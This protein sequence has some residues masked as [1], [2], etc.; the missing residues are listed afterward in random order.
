MLPRLTLVLLLLAPKCWDYGYAPS[1]L[2]CVSGLF[3]LRQV[4]C[5]VAQAFLKLIAI[6][7]PQLPRMLWL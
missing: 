1:H 2:V 7:L 4:S 6:H 5:Y 3:V